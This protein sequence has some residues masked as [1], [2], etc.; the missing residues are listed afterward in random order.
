MITLYDTYCDKLA[1]AKSYLIKG[2]IDPC[3]QGES[4]LNDAL[5]LKEE[6]QLHF[7]NEI[8]CSIEKL[9]AKIYQCKYWALVLEARRLTHA[10]REMFGPKSSKI[11]KVDLNSEQQPCETDVVY[12]PIGHIGVKYV[13][14]TY[15]CQPINLAKMGDPAYYKKIAA[16]VDN[17]VLQVYCEKSMRCKEDF[18]IYLEGH[19]DGHRFNGR[20]YDRSLN[21]PEGTPYTHFHKVSLEQIDTIQK[22]QEISRQNK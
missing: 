13:I 10:E 3:E 15:L 20:R 22:Q 16:W 9:K 18:F 11:M 14:S 17:E 8:N 21:I 4:Y 7:D 1:Q 2:H 6:Y 19:T 12:E 5:E